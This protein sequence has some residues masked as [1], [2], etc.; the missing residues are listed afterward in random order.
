MAVFTV[1]EH[2]ELD[3]AAATVTLDAEGSSIPTSYDHLL[4][5]ASIR[6]DNASYY[7]GSA[8][9]LGTGGTIDTGSTYSNTALWA[10]SGTPVS[11]REAARTELVNVFYQ[12]N[13]GTADTFGS[14]SIW[15]P[16]YTASTFKQLLCTSCV[17][18]ATTTSSQ[19]VTAITAGLWANTGAVTSVLM[20]TNGSG[21]FMEFS[22]FTLYGILGA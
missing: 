16:N 12:G 1:I 2:V 8:I 9:Q 19:W 13:S 17:E 15:I 18:G 20:A 10:M 5:K 14:V 22:T 6:N 11:S 7:R 21:D 3:A 4:I